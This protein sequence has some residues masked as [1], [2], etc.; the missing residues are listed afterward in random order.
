[1]DERE[2]FRRLFRDEP[3]DRPPLLDEG[4]R[5]E[6]IDLWRKQGMPA[7]KTHLEIFGLTPHE[8]VGPDIRFRPRYA[9]RVMD[10]A[11]KDYRRAFDIARTRF[12]P[13]WHE[14]SKRLETRDQIACIWASRGFF[15]ALGVMDWLT[16]RQALLA[17]INHPKRVRNRME[18]YGDFCAG[19][20]ELSLRDVD[21]EFIYLSEPISDNNGPLI[22][23]AMFEEFMIPAYEKIIAVAR[24]HG[25][26]DILVNTYGNTAKLIPSMMGAG[27]NI[28][29]VSEAAANAEMDYRNLR[30]QYGRGLGLIGGIPLD[31]L[32]GEAQQEVKHRLHEIVPPLMESG[33]YIPLASGRVREEIPWSAYRGYREALAGI[34]G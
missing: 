19:M 33:R 14:T 10:L 34:M 15:Q 24:A 17:V 11:L 21:P 8:N 27:V 20:L 4:V 25:C 5:E 26:Q 6:V 18:A 13:E 30:R 22:P 31:I 7:E 29:W 32:R 23:P 9:G 1:M 12:P 2:R 3:V 16:L 28:L